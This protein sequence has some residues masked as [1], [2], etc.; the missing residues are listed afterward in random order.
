M[1]MVNSCF[2]E[3]AMFNTYFQFV[4]D[5]QT[6]VLYFTYVLISQRN[7]FFSLSSAWFLVHIHTKDPFDI[8]K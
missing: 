6:H 7:D 3:L 1:M 8:S 5:Q 2:D 4:F